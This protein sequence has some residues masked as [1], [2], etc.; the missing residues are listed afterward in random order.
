MKKEIKVFAPASVTN[1]SCG[2]DVMGFAIECPGDELILRIKEKP[3][4]YYFK[5]YRRP[6]EASKIC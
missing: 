5:N 3:G 1:V 6:W 4:Y 2:F